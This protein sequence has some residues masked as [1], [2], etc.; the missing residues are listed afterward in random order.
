MKKTYRV[1]GY[2]KPEWLLRIEADRA[3]QARSADIQAAVIFAA[4]VVFLVLLVSFRL[5]FLRGV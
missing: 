4:A 3:R 2:K 1:I 5:N